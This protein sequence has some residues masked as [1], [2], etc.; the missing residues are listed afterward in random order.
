MALNIPIIVYVG[1]KEEYL[2]EPLLQKYD[3]IR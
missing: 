3:Y 2:K 1:E